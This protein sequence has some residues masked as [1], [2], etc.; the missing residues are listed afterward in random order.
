MRT[1]MVGELNEATKQQ[2]VEMATI[3]DRVHLHQPM[4]LSHASYRSVSCSIHS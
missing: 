3:G 1:E 4:L 2:L